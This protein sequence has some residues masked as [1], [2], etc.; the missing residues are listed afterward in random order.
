[1]KINT[2]P[3]VTKIKDVPSGTVVDHVGRNDLQIVMSYTHTDNDRDV[4]RYI[5]SLITGRM[6]GIWEGCDYFVRDNV[7]LEIREPDA[8]EAK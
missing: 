5:V 6:V 4:Y 7:Q 2:A 8:A 3:I 1:M